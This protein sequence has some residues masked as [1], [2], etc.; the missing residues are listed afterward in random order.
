MEGKQKGV[1]GTV[2]NW[3]VQFL[4]REARRPLLSSGRTVTGVLLDL[5]QSPKFQWMETNSKIKNKNTGQVK[6]KKNFVGEFNADLEYY[7]DT[8]CFKVR[9]GFYECR[10]NIGEAWGFL[11]IFLPPDTPTHQS[12][13][14]LNF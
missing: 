10:T 7:K 14:F 9:K 12:M 11:F 8:Q 3:T 2:M 6:L 5:L 4:S 1:M 13:V